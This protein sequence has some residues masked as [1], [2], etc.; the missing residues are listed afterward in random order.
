MVWAY[1]P[2]TNGRPVY[3]TGIQGVNVINGGSG[4]SAASVTFS[5]PPAG[6]TTATGTVTLSS[7]VVTGIVMTNYGSGYNNTYPTIIDYSRSF[8]LINFVLV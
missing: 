3:T 1:K 4:Y 2:D 6:G 7:G 5:A 8:I